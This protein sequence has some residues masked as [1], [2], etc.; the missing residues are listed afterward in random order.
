LIATKLVRVSGQVLTSTG[1]PA[2]GGT[3]ILVPG[4]IAAGRGI[5][6]QQGGGG[7]R[8]DRTGAF[9]VG[10]GAPGRHQ[11]QAMT[12]RRRAQ[13]LCRAR[14]DAAVGARPADGSTRGEARE[15]RPA[16][17]GDVAG[18]S[19]GGGGSGDRRT[20]AR[21]RVGAPQLRP[22]AARPR[23]SGWGPVGS[24]FK[25]TR[26]VAAESLRGTAV[27]TFA[28]CGGSVR[29]RTPI[30]AASWKWRCE[31]ASSPAT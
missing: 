3:V 7:G 17:G 26:G 14:L 6:M 9:T 2:A 19:L 11:V 31:P 5:V 27:L 24:V 25:R 21:L 1:A 29:G 30:R 12:G 15:A 4:G 13:V 20:G 18:E 28:A 23:G 8:L 10:T 22:G 16:V